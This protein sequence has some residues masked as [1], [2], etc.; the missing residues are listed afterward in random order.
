MK[1]SKL[2]QRA[3]EQRGYFLLEIL[4]TVVVLSL[5]LL[6]VAAMQYTGLK[7]NNRSNERSLATILAYDIIDR[8]RANRTGAQNGDYRIPDP[9]TAP[10]IPNG[11]VYNC[12]DNFNGTATANICSATEMASADLVQWWNNAL[13]VLPNGAA[14]ILCTDGAGTAIDPCPAGSVHEVV[15]FWDD[16]RT[17]ATG[18]GAINNN[19]VP[20]N[21]NADMACMAFDVEL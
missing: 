20:T 6:G 13:G 3:S 15:I 5:G 18:T 11:G 8:M 4:I 16:A 1:N 7:D 17:G 19:C 10:T 21:A 2:Q 12:I 14:R 9:A